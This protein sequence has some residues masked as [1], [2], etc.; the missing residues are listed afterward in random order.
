MIQGLQMIVAGLN[1]LRDKRV[2]VW[3]ICLDKSVWHVTNIIQPKINKPPEQ[4]QTNKNKTNYREML[5]VN[6]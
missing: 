2:P 6:S 3:I 1:C 4:V 5:I